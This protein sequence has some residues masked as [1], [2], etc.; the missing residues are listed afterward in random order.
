MSAVHVEDAV[1][2]RPITRASFDHTFVNG[3]GG[4]YDVALRPP[5]DTVFVTYADGYEPR[6][7]DYLFGAFVALT[8]KSK[9]GGQ[10]SCF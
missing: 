8:P 6:Q 4:Y 3:G 7:W 5:G 10:G 9:A 2:N 1:T